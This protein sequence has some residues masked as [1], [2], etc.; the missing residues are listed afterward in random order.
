M[1]SN[2]ERPEYPALYDSSNNASLESQKHYLLVMKWYLGLSILAAILSI[3]IKESTIAGIIATIAFFAILFL[4]IFQA[5]KRFDK[6]W[7]NG[8]A[9]AESVKTRTWRFVMRAEPYFDTDNISDIKAEFCSDLKD[10]LEQ[11]RELGSYLAHESVTKET[12]TD[13]MLE[14]RARDITDRLNYYISNRIN[15]QRTW[16]L[17]KANINKRKARDWFIGLIATNSVIIVLLLIEIGYNVYNL[18]TPALIVVGGSIL[19]WTQIKKFQ[20]LAT[21]YSLTA[22]EIGI[23]KSQSF[24]VSGE[25]EMSDFVKDAENAFSREHTQWVARKDK[26]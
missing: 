24:L 8:R 1:Q 2:Y 3:Y 9:V 25:K 14:I 18:P 20:D 26:Q 15:E 23:I 17:T 6:T 21:S 4:T 7:Y 22:H 12:I 13:S 11:N 5:V 19:S 16:Y 10:I